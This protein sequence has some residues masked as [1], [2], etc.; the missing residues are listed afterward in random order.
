MDKNAQWRKFYWEVDF[1]ARKGEEI[2]GAF[3][4]LKPPVDVFKIIRAE[5]RLIH[6]V[7]ED[8]GKAFDG[9]IRFVGTRF[10]LCYNT[11]Y[12]E[13]PHSGRHHSK[14]LFSIAHEL[15]HYFLDNHREYLI[16][17]KQP[18]D[19]FSEFSSHKLVE[20]QADSFAAGM[21]MP[22]DLLGAIVNK[23]NIPSVKLILETTRLFEVSLTGLLSRWTQIS[24]FPCATIATQDGVIKFGWVSEAFREIGCYRVRRGTAVQFGDFRR[25]AQQVTPIAKY[26][27]GE[28]T[29][30]TD[31]WL[32][33][34]GPT[35]DTEEFYFAIPHTGMIWVFITCDERELS[36]D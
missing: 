18:H 32:D 24:H 9:R 23:Q 10:L 13:W 12:N 6:A 15:G 33:W 34:D 7:G 31:Q 3:D 4:H 36:D 8:F 27:D 20:R 17:S 19:S 29:G 1:A 28:G 22:R 2:A 14:I 16:A 26:R 11:R 21:L 5:R 35:F 30:H 25:F